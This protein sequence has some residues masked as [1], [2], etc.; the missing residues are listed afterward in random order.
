MIAT[1]LAGLISAALQQQP[2]ID[3]TIVDSATHAPIARVIVLD[4]ASRRQALTDSAG[5]F[6]IA[7]PM[8][9]TLRF[10]HVG[11]ATREVVAT[12]ADLRIELPPSPRTLERVTVMAIRGG[13]D[14][15]APVSQRTVTHDEIERRSFGQ[16][17]PLLLQSS[18]PSMTAYAETGNYWGYSYM[19]LRGI[20]Q[21]RINLTIDGIP[22]NDPEDQ[23]LYFADF[24]DLASSLESVQVQRG[25][26]T[27]SAGTASFAGSIN[28]ET[29]P[30]AGKAGS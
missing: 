18:T 23:V 27:S 21:S 20:D 2:I 5:R 10:A 4:V 24:P 1:I 6:T 14:E 26:G 19:R 7:V 15:A 28:F 3:G 17:V 30:L 16:E 12:T 8:P 25:V 11:Y 29:T 22:L 9:A 13:A